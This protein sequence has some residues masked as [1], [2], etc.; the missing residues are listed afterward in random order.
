[1]NAEFPKMSLSQAQGY[2]KAQDFQNGLA[3]YDLKKVL[4][5]GRFQNKLYAQVQGSGSSNYNVLLEFTDTVKPKCT[6]PAARKTP[7][8]KHTAAV[9]AG[10]AKDPNAFMATENP[11]E[12]ASPKSKKARVKTGEAQTADLIA[13]GLESLETLVIELGL[14]GL[15]T[16]T[17]SRVEQVRDLAENLRTYKLRRLATLLTQF[18]D[19]LNT[20]LTDQEKFSLATYADL[21]SDIVLT[22]KG[23]MAIQQGKL[24]DPKYMEEL[25]GKTWTDKELTPRA[26]L[27]LVGV[28]FE[29]AE[30]ADGFVVFSNYFVELSAGEILTKKFIIPKSLLKRA[31]ENDTQSYCGLKLTAS[32]ALQYPGFPPLRLKFKEVTEHPITVQDVET[33]A[34][35]A[36][37]DFAKEVAAFQA[38]KKDFFAPPDYYTVLKPKGFYAAA[39]GLSIFDENGK[40]FELILTNRGTV[41]LEQML[42]ASQVSAL[43]GKIQAINGSL[44]F[45]PLSAIVRS[46]EKPVIPL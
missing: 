15:S 42:G 24:Q 8:C 6:C 5:P 39:Q 12:L 34:A 11:P 37:G 19:L 2:F 10:W 43:F 25:V 46:Q 32:E 26:N 27:Q 16:I 13:R 33:I 38:F 14:S 30:T 17:A 41:T 7:F 29:H 35:K 44:K 20:L 40:A 18:A 9:L 4:N 1:M 36:N 3:Y 28:F 45:E 22:T 21:L 23:V 31:A